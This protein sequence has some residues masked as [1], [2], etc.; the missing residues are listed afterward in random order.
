MGGKGLALI[1]IASYREGYEAHIARSLLDEAGIAAFVSDEHLVSVNWLYSQA[2]GGVKLQVPEEQ[3]ERALE[4]LAEAWGT[5]VETDERPAS[6]SEDCPSCGSTA[7]QFDR[8]DNRLRAFSLWLSLPLSIGGYR[9]RCEECGHTWR[10]VP[11]YRGLLGILGQMIALVA[12][13][14][15]AVVRLPLRFLAVITGSASSAEF[16]CWSCEGIYRS[17]NAECPH[18]GIQLPDNEAYRELVR[19]GRAYDGACERCHT[20]FAIEDYDPL[21]AVRACSRCGDDL[22]L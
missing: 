12:L 4:T 2:L 15:L 14:V 20:P 19:V 13:L 1:T 3:A 8:L 18:C 22:S 10:R 5:V 9:W 21:S 11:E 6:R 16:Y 7:T 17:G